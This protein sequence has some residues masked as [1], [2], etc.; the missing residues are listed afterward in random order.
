MKKLFLLI[1]FNFLFLQI[2]AQN[3]VFDEIEKAIT[4]REQGD[5]DKA[6]VLL[7]E[8]LIKAPNNAKVY[9]ERGRTYFIQEKYAKALIDYNKAIHL[10][11]KDYRFFNEKAIVFLKQEKLEEAIQTIDKALALEANN[12]TVWGNKAFILYEAKRFEETIESFQKVLDLK[13]DLEN[14]KIFDLMAISYRELKQYDKAVDFFGKAITVKDLPEY[15]YERGIT[16]QKQEKL[17][18]ACHDWQN[19]YLRDNQ[20]AAKAMQ[21]YCGS[22]PEENKVKFYVD[23]QVNLLSQKQRNYLEQV[24]RNYEDSTSTQINLV[25]IKTLNGKKL[26]EYSIKLAESKGI[27]QAEKDNGILILIVKNDRKIRIENGYGIETVLTDAKTRHI[28][29]KMTTYFKSNQYYKGIYLGIQDIFK[30]LEGAFDANGKLK[31]RKSQEASAFAVGITAT[32]VIGFIALLSFTLASIIFIFFLLFMIMKQLFWAIPSLLIALIFLY[33]SLK[34]KGIFGSVQNA[35]KSSG[36]GSSYSSGNS[37]S[38]SS[39]YSSYS[40][41]S[42]SSWGGGS[43]GGGGASGDW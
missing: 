34:R 29:K 2:F 30:T 20:K 17:E 27:G 19:A 31:K 36:S 35:L 8:L 3:Q 1:L 6:L 7:S 15:Y 43:F 9:R 23:D 41:Y 38:S 21:K 32:L 22:L 4:Y 11:A 16:Y 18:K 39:S 37:S 5:F 28:I 42:D 40:D 26:E 33:L 14:A 10:N 24:F 12:I 25:I 13:P